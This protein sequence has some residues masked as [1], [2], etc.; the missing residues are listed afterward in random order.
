VEDLASKRHVAHFGAFELDLRTGDVRKN[1][2][3]RRLAGQPFQLLTLLLASAGEVVPREAL[4]KRLW[5]EDTF[6]D[7][8]HSLGVAINKI[9]EALGD[10]ADS[11]RYVETV[12]G[13]GYRFIAP[14]TWGDG[15]GP[16]PP[17]GA[18][19]QSHPV[20]QEEGP[21]TPGKPSNGINRAGVVANVFGTSFSPVAPA[22]VGANPVTGT[23]NLLSSD[24][25]SATP[26]PSPQLKAGT[27]KHWWGR[28]AM[29][30]A[31][32]IATLAFVLVLGWSRFQSPGRVEPEIKHI[33]L[34]FN[35]D[36]NP[37]TSWSISPRGHYLAYSDAA[38][39]VSSQ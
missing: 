9:R 12:R 37:V 20:S 28:R 26:V 13:R 36:E 17:S 6:V 21:D 10:S 31:A 5:P 18:G 3:K 39:I 8:N 11:P 23:K 30:A 29:I 1:G 24:S 25:E 7:F 19:P 15:A 27:V 32:A 22:V 4:R 2:L 14:V 35:S 16:A 33:R 38:G 34:T